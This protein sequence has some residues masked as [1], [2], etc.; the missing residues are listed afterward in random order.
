MQV[1]RV[2]SLAELHKL[3]NISLALFTGSK[4]ADT[5]KSWCPDCVMAEPKIQKMI[6]ADNFKGHHLA[7]CSIPRDEWKSAANVYKAD[8]K[9]KVMSVPT[10]LVWEN[11]AVRLAESNILDYGAIDMLAEE[12]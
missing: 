1:S 10:L 2:T 4:N 11:P 6:E 12:L 8:K 3:S 7:I 9:L 5:G